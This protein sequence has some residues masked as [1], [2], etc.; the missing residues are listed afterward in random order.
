VLGGAMVLTAAA[1]FE[2]DRVLAANGLTLLGAVMIALFVLLFGWIA[3]A[4]TSALG[5]FWRV[6]RGTSWLGIDPAAPLPA[7]AARTALLMPAYNEQPGRVFAAVEAMAESLEA[8]GAAAW[9]DL[10]IL[11]DTTDPETWIAEEAAFLALRARPGVRIFYRHRPRNI[12]RKAGNVADWVR[13]FGAAYPHFLILDADSVM[14]GETLARLAAAME[15]NPRVGLIQTL[16]VIVGATTLFGRLQQ[17][18][19]RVYGP[20]IAHGLACWHGAEGNYWGHNAMIR[21]RAFAACAGLPELR[22]RAPFGG[23]ILSHDF[24]EAAL[25]RRGGWEVHMVPSLPGSFEEAPP[26]LTDLALRDRRWCQGNLQHAAVLPAR[27]LHW[28]SRLHLLSGIFSYAAAPLWLLFLLIGLMI[29]LQARLEPFDY[30]P[31]G[32]ALFP[33][34]PQVD[35]V[36]ARTLFEATMAVLLAPK[37]LGTCA[38]LL[39]GER[40]RYGG[41]ARLL[42]GVGI[43]AVCAALI[44]PVAMLTQTRDVLA[45]LAGRDAGWRPQRRDDGLIAR[46]E[47]VRRYAPHSALGLALGLGAYQVSPSLALWMLPVVAGLLLAIPLA[48]GTASRAAGQVLRGLGLL[49]IPEET[50]PPPVLRRAADLRHRWRA[51]T[52]S[53]VHRLLADPCLW[54]AHAA[55]QP[56]PR[57]RREGPIPV[58]LVLGLAKLE[59]AETLDEALD[60]VAPAELAAALADPRGLALLAALRRAPLAVAS[61]P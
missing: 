49:R 19:A 25:L 55:M 42:L 44:A 13:R 58:P 18:A 31:A 8:V 33:R 11:S 43:E 24:V 29:A 40:R 23:P 15:R 30:F 2:M 46:G 4:F 32:R 41:A 52:G 47:V 38:V 7:L 21:T 39:R 35:P 51:R 56:P 12:G 20:V 6:L 9:F 34:W 10:F 36:R 45:T 22:G 37:L 57:G 54:R 16:P 27:G 14:S 48:I 3:L 50:E 26:S 5:G 17:F 61:A 60:A 28:V 1:G 53:W 59:E